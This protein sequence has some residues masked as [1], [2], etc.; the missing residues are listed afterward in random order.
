MSKGLG[1]ELGFLFI[2]GDAV[3]EICERNDHALLPFVIPANQGIFCVAD[4]IKIFF[5]KLWLKA[6]NWINKKCS[7]SLHEVN[8]RTERILLSFCHFLVIGAKCE[9][10]S[11]SRRY[12]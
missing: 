4:V 2:E 12:Y 6:Q 8:N 11:G 10:L 1:K 5:R 3:E 7:G 9:D